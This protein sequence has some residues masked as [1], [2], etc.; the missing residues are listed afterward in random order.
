[1]LQQGQA[2]QIEYYDQR[3]HDIDEDHRQALARAI[4][5][6]PIDGTTTRPAII[7]SLKQS[8]QTQKEADDL[9][10]RALEQ[11]MIDQ[12][13]LGCYGILIPPLHKWLVDEYAKGKD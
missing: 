13:S 2:E 9:F 7:S 6:V 12:R 8:G 3:A 4:M 10:T 11:G 1:V 5:D